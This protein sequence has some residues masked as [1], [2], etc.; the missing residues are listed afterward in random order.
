M[1]E[2]TLKEYY[3]ERM[4]KEREKFKSFTATVDKEVG[5]AFT[6]LINEKGIPFRQWLK[7]KMEEE[8]ESNGIEI[9]GDK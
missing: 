9:N 3:K 1:K 8:L 4:A 7:L 5:N 2:K 6:K